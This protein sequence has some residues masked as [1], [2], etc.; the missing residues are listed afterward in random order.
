MNWKEFGRKWSWLNVK[1]LSR[2]L[3]ERTEENYENLRIAGLQAE[4]GIPR[5]TEY[6]AELL[7]CHELGTFTQNTSEN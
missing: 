5:T 6:E 2:H 7:L 1:V 4:T 3:P